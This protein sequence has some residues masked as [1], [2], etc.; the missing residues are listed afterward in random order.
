LA[1]SV[2]E[3]AL[4]LQR[5]SGSLFGGTVEASGEF[6]GAATPALRGRLTLRDAD[7]KQA[8]HD[9]AGLGLVDG[10]VD[11]DADVA[12]TGSSAAEMIASL[13]GTA[14]LHGHDGSISGVALKAMNDQLAQHPTNLLALL[15]GGAG[16]RTAFSTLDGTFHLADGIA[17]SDDLHLVAEGG[18]GT[19]TVSIDL[20]KWVM[21]SEVDFRLAAA[22]DAPPLVMRVNGAIDQPRIVL[23]INA[24]EKFLG[25]PTP[26]P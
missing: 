25:Q 4:S 2:K 18:D 5:L 12:G 14:T 23:D 22:A 8:L 3:G 26:R 16:G 1:L 21:A 9:A 19:A 24:L 13:A 17:R 20:P 11:I 7:L 15:R 6:G 10:H